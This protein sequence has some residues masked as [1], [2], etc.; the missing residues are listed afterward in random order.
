[1]RR[2]LWPTSSRCVEGGGAD[3]PGRQAGGTILLQC[4]GG[5]CCISQSTAASC[6]CLAQLRASARYKVRTKEEWQLA[7]DESFTF[8]MPV[9]INWCEDRGNSNCLD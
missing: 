2:A 4:Q 6:C 5:Y 3:D 9:V 1:M 7:V 8:Q